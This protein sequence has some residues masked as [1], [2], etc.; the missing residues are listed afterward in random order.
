MPSKSI[1]MTET[2]RDWRLIR[3]LR[4]RLWVYI[5]SRLGNGVHSFIY[6]AML[7][8]LW[9]GFL[10]QVH[11]SNNQLFV[12]FR[13]SEKQSCRGGDCGDFML[14]TAY[15]KEFA[16]IGRFCGDRTCAKDEGNTASF[17]SVIRDR[18]YSKEGTVIAV[19]SR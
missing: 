11:G 14:Y 6:E 17:L 2:S 19:S 15:G 3:L 16:K 4:D 8:G 13:Y 7:E 9:F 5:Y 18:S 10:N 1:V 12:C